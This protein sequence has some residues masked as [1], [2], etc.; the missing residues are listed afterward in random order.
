MT[1]KLPI[2]SFLL[3][4][5]SEIPHFWFGGNLYLTQFM[6]FNFAI[7]P[8]L[9]R[10]L[11]RQTKK[12]IGEIK[13]PE[14]KTQLEWFIR[15][16]AQHYKAHEEYNRWL[17][18]RGYPI[19]ETLER[20]DAMLRHV[21]ENYSA[22]TVLGFCCFTEHMTAVLSRMFIAN[23]EVFDHV[24]DTMA[25]LMKWHGMEELEHKS[26][27]Y[28]LFLAMGG[29]YRIRVASSF[30]QLRLLVSA[31]RKNWRSFLAIDRQHL[32]RKEFKRALNF[33]S[34]HFDNRSSLREFFEYYKPGFHPSS[35]DDTKL[36][37][38]LQKQLGF[39]VEEASN[40]GDS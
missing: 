19:Q 8:P 7:L 24:D 22:R 1:K 29:N 14:L 34:Q 5:T 33:G 25:K 20:I 18:H 31:H 40:K 26:A 6:N 39:Q 23:Y 12:Y 15:Q 13:E 37:A 11:I 35:T 17:E 27:M 2:R 10:F 21:E 28:D 3:P 32:S 36:I 4:F 16:E 38:T 30:L 9:E